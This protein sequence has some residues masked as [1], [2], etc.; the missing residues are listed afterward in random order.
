MTVSSCST[1]TF[2]DSRLH[3]KNSSATPSTPCLRNW[4][5]AARIDGASSLVIFRRVMLPIVRPTVITVALFAFLAAWNEFLAAVVLL[6]KS[7][8]ETLPVILL[9]VQLG[10]VGTVDWGALEAGTTPAFLPCVLLYLT[11]QRYY[12]TGFTAGAVKA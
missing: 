5:D 2:R 9:N 1:G 11:L 8:N 10:N 12:L 3:P 4:K 6:S 7:E